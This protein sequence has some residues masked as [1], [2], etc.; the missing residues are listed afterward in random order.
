MKQKDNSSLITGLAIGAAFILGKKLWRRRNG[1]SF[2]GKAVLIT[3]GSR[4]MGLEIARVL[5]AEGAKVAILARDGSELG[6]ARDDLMARAQDGAEVLSVVC[7]VSDEDSVNNAVARVAH[8][9]GRLD[10][11]I[12]NAGI[13]QVGPLEH[14]QLE[15]FDYALSINLRGALMMM[16]AAIPHLKKAAR[17][18]GYQGARIV[19][20]ASLGGKVALP[21]FAPYSMTKFGLVGLSDSIRSELAKDGVRVTTVCPGPMRTG[22]HVNAYFKGRHEA[23]YAMFSSQAGMPGGSIASDNAAR[24]IVDA[25][26]HGDANLTFPLMARISSAG[27]QIFPRVTAFVLAG[28]AMKMPKPTGREGDALK[29]GAQSQSEKS[30][31]LLSK[32]ADNSI[33]PNNEAA[34]PVALR[35][36]SVNGHA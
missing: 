33:G 29:T 20:I 6:R 14:M 18:N 2:A 10:V 36:A 25:C 5:V 35:D 28:A 8:H 7:D 21:H 15:D 9:F 26:R 27:A 12:N 23:E 3:G 31:N 34:A 13:I 1:M 30:P 32:L 19:N 4:G 16:L 24:Q 11:L 22:S 17:K